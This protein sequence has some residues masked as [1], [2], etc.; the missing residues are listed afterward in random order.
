MKVLAAQSARQLR[1]Q[2]DYI[3]IASK[4]SGAREF[5]RLD[6]SLKGL[7]GRAFEAPKSTYCVPARS[8]YCSHSVCPQPRRQIWLNQP[9]VG[10]Q[11]NVSREA[12]RH[13]Y[14][15]PTDLQAMP[16]TA[17]SPKPCD[18]WRAGECSEADCCKAAGS[19]LR[20]YLVL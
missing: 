20:A 17:D 2:L 11:R 7:N 1:Q 10:K 4:Q 14:Y 18:C 12:C 8:R 19:C 5:R 9:G 3:E 15:R 13:L 16:S 6:F